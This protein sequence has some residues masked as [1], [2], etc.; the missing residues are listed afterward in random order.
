LYQETASTKKVTR[1]E[2]ADAAAQLN[3]H[4]ASLGAEST[5]SSA[6][7]NQSAAD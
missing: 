7:L 3:F 6:A 4:Y 1:E 5:R 2:A